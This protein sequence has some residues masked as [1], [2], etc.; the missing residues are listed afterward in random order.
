[1]IDNIGYNVKK[2]LGYDKADLR[3][4]NTSILLPEFYRKYHETVIKSMILSLSTQE[5]AFFKKN[6]IA[7]HKDG[8]YIPA[9]VEL[10]L[11]YN[12]DG[13]LLMEGFIEVKSDP[14][15]IWTNFFFTKYKQEKIV[16]VGPIFRKSLSCRQGRWSRY[17]N[18]LKMNIPKKI[19]SQPPTQSR[20]LSRTQ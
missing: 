7:R 17:P 20:Q 3:G 1:M 9:M 12:V 16:E 4:A 8:Y 2:L 14:R 6:V 11:V 15:Y 5:F 19:I 10:K 13:D 18:I